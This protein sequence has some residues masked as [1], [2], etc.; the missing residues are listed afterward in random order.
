MVPTILSE[1]SALS[2]GKR[3]HHQRSSRHAM[4]PLSDTSPHPGGK[5]PLNSAFLDGAPPQPGEIGCVVST[6]SETAW[7]AGAAVL[8][9]RHVRGCAVAVGGGGPRHAAAASLVAG[10]GAHGRY[11]AQRAHDGATTRQPRA[12]AASRLAAAAAAAHRERQQPP[13]G[14]LS[15][16]VS[17][18]IL[19]HVDRRAWHKPWTRTRDSCSA[20]FRLTWLIHPTSNTG[21]RSE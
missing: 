6:H 15:R 19:S 21:F 3:L 11:L 16:L 7:N 9:V 17:R 12:A 13:A 2:P 5:D 10:V 20:T 4:V 14:A 8:S 18:F 1:R